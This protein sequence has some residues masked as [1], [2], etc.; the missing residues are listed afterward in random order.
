MKAIPLFKM[1][2]DLMKPIIIMGI[3][4]T[5]LL[6]CAG[7]VSSQ[8]NGYNYEEENRD[9]AQIEH[10]ARV[11]REHENASFDFCCAVSGRALALMT[12]AAELLE[13]Q[14]DEMFRVERYAFSIAYLDG[15]AYVS[16]IPFSSGD[17]LSRVAEAEYNVV[18]DLLTNEVQDFY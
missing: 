7:A 15:K 13:E 5:L 16:A 12:I 6:G 4:S 1:R 11:V 2:A 18:I 17:V 14:G 3:S 10:F 9:L 8:P